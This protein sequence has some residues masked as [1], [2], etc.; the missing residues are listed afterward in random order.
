MKN[1]Q[2]LWRAI[3]VLRKKTKSVKSAFKVFFVIYLHN[4]D[5]ILKSRKLFCIHWRLLTSEWFMDYIYISVHHMKWFYCHIMLGLCPCLAFIKSSS[6]LPPLYALIRNRD[7]SQFCVS[8]FKCNVNINKKWFSRGR[9]HVYRVLS[10]KNF[11]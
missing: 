8:V 3:S 1:V 10:A 5:I 9:T 6:Y 4:I 7:T 11:N 2:V